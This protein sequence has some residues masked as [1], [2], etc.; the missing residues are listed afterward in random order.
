MLGKNRWQPILGL[1]VFTVS[2]LK[3]SVSFAQVSFGYLKITQIYTQNFPEIKVQAIVRDEK[4]EVLSVTDM[5]NL[6]LLENQQEVTPLNIEVIEGPIEVMFVLD[7]GPYL[8]RTGAITIQGEGGVTRKATRLEGILDI[9]GAFL[10]AMRSGDSVGI[11]TVGPFQDPQV[12]IL[13][14]LT[15]DQDLLKS[16]LASLATIPITSQRA[17]QAVQALDEA[18]TALQNSQMNKQNAIQAV[19]LVS[20]GNIHNFA[21]PNYSAVLE[22]AQ[23]LAI[24]IH[25]ILVHEYDVSW[26]SGK[27][28][29]VARETNGRFV[30]Y[31]SNQDRQL[32]PQWA[33]EQRSQILFTYRS[34]IGASGSRTVELRTKGK[35]ISR[36]SSTR[37]YEV[38]ILP[39]EVS[40]QDPLDGATL[41][42]T[43]SEGETVDLASPKSTTVIANIHWPDGH[44]RII[45][46]AKLIITGDSN[47]EVVSFYPAGDN[48]RF[49]VDLTP[50]TKEEPTEILMW[51][52]VTEEL[53]DPVTGNP[54]VWTSPRQRLSIDVIPTASTAGNLLKTFPSDCEK[55]AGLPYALCLG[56]RYAWLIS[57]SLSSIALLLVVIFRTRIAGAAIQVGDSIR[58]TVARI[59]RPQKTE[60]GAYLQVL[61]GANDLPRDRLPLYLNTVTPIGR[62]K[63]QADL[64]FDEHAEQ[65]VVSRLHCE[66]IS[67]GRVFTIRDKGSTHGTYVNAKRL[68]ELGSQQLQDG[69]QIEI[70]PVERGGILLRFELVAEEEAQMMPFESDIIDRETRPMV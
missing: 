12:N 13:Q 32:I 19:V 24:P 60:V 21:S 16:K 18:L 66:I 69:D 46:Q 10:D 29:E 1:L 57:L 61:K 11:I 40:I 50:F 65:S 35:G 49:T 55:L 31:Q 36:K 33:N 9:T 23:Q 63:R 20:D 39:P 59:T 62:D 17:S 52:E 45:Q 4:G 14:N 28:R 47:Q 53:K 44:Q 43:Y 67:E 38:S 48:I 64:I 58:E 54:L 25:T 3:P 7:L 56:Q 42:R 2:L 70:G 34:Q 22:R 26:S 6:E 37:K 68:P 51:V 30:F 27:L 5:A 15:M 8:D 41:H